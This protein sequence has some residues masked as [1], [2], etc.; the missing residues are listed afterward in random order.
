MASSSS[1]VATGKFFSKPISKRLDWIPLHPGIN[2]V[3]GSIG[4]DDRVPLM[5]ANRPVRAGF[6]QCGTLSRTGTSHRLLHNLPHGKH[7]ISVNGY[8]R[9]TVSCSFCCYIRVQRRAFER[10]C[11]RIEIVFAD[12]YDGRHL[13]GGKIDG[14]VKRPVVDCTITKK[15][16][17]RCHQRHVGARPI[18]CLRHG[19]FRPR[20]FRWSQTG[21]RI[22]HRDASCRRVLRRFRR[23][24]QTARP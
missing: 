8:C 16:R 2:L 23:F 13:N 14:F 3:L 6:N 5:V 9:A 12:K 7:I 15:K 24:F 10:C 20:Q 21:P 18:R 19:Q 11:C 4:P 1:L 17:P 22:G